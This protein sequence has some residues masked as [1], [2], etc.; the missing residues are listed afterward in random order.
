MTLESLG[1]RLPLS[2]RAP[3]NAPPVDS[4]AVDNSPE[5]GPPPPGAVESITP[6]LG[7]YERYADGVAPEVAAATETV[8][9]ALAIPVNIDE[10]ELFAQGE[11]LGEALPELPLAD[12]A[13]TVLDPAEITEMQALLEGLSEQLQSDVQVLALR[14]GLPLEGFRSEGRLP[15]AQ[16]Q[17]LEA[18]PQNLADLEHALRSAIT[19]LSASSDIEH[20]AELLSQLQTGLQEVSA[21]QSLLEHSAA[22]NSARLE[23]LA[24]PGNLRAYGSRMDAL[25][26]QQQEFVSAMANTGLE[27]DWMDQASAEILALTRSDAEALRGIVEAPEAGLVDLALGAGKNYFNVRGRQGRLNRLAYYS[28]FIADRRA[29]GRDRSNESANPQGYLAGLQ[30]EVHDSEERRQQ[31]ARLSQDIVSR[32]NRPMSDGEIRARVN[33]IFPVRHDGTRIVSQRVY[34]F[35]LSSFLAEGAS[36]RSN[37]HL[38]Q[39]RAHLGA[40]GENLGDARAHLSDDEIRQARQEILETRRSLQSADDH[41]S[42]GTVASRRA[43]QGENIQAL[44]GVPDAGERV[45]TTRASVSGRATED[46]FAAVQD[47]IA[48]LEDESNEVEA[49]VDRREAELQPEENVAAGG[50]A[51]LSMPLFSGER[52]PGVAPPADYLERLE[53]YSDNFQTLLEDRLDAPDVRG[54]SPSEEM[55]TL[56]QYRQAMR[57]L[58]RFQSGVME[59]GERE[60]FEGRRAAVEA[61]F[62]ELSNAPAVQNM[63]R[64]IQQEALSNTGLDGENGNYGPEDHADYILSFE[65]EVEMSALSLSER[66]ARVSQEISRLAVV[67]AGMA[68]NVVERLQQAQNQRQP[69]EILFEGQTPA[70]QEANVARALDAFAQEVRQSFMSMRSDEAREAAFNQLLQ[71]IGGGSDASL[72]WQKWLSD[73]GDESVLRQAQTI[74]GPEL[75]NADFS[76]LIRRGGGDLTAAIRHSGSDSARLLL[77]FINVRSSESGLRMVGAAAGVIGSLA[78]P[79]AALS[80]IPSGFSQ[81][82]ATADPFLS[83]SRNPAWTALRAGA[84]EVTGIYGDL[85]ALSRSLTSLTQGRYT[86]GGNRDLQLLTAGTAVV[87]AGLGV[88]ALAG[89][90]IPGANVLA[91]GTAATAA[92]V[93]YAQKHYGETQREEDVYELLGDLGITAEE[94]DSRSRLS[95]AL[96]TMGPLGESLTDQQVTDIV[97]SLV[98]RRP[99]GFL[100]SIALRSGGN[101]LGLPAGIL[102]HFRNIRARGAENDAEALELL[103]QVAAS[104]SGFSRAQQQAILSRLPVETF[105]HNFDS[106]SEAQELAGLMFSLNGDQSSPQLEQYLTSLSDREDFSAVESV[107]GSLRGRRIGEESALETL[108]LDTIMD[109][110]VNYIQD[111]RTEDALRLVMERINTPSGRDE[112]VP[113]TRGRQG[114]LRNIIQGDWLGRL[115]ATGARYRG[116]PIAHA[117]YNGLRERMPSLPE[118]P[119]QYLGYQET[120]PRVT[121]VRRRADQLIDRVSSWRSSGD[122]DA[123]AAERVSQE[124]HDF[125]NGTSSAERETLAERPRGKVEE[126]LELLTTEYQRGNRNHLASF[127]TVLAGTDRG[128]R[129][130]LIEAFEARHPEIAQQAIN[131]ATRALITAHE[132]H[133]REREEEQ[134][135]IDSGQGFPFNPMGA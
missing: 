131:P 89:L 49:A 7:R 84:A 100:A 96:D 68:H 111:N 17:Q 5:T 34:D 24:T 132:E 18:M 115:N 122:Y 56:F 6:A 39:S 114:E 75:S 113:L 43:A 3:D 44:E 82:L 133:L 36:V 61:R 79:T 78:D 37:Y 74:L 35:F 73:L 60:A 98:N 93:S 14:A 104:E 50:I 95:D 21:T 41:A 66:E 64:S 91:V 110:A 128:N 57:L 92:L 27:A 101:P 8:M 11:L 12:L 127:L 52:T 33:D 81:G 22:L 15:Q 70:E 59:Q 119:H 71:N 30:N 47:E 67:D 16:A 99:E 108:S 65:F 120:R 121:D 103:A 134:R 117:I 87:G 125:Y 51:G 10:A 106:A 77:G 4:A 25:A 20:H 112:M 102:S 23:L 83:F 63:M 129:F 116:E 55:Q 31:C 105:A 135:R 130:E 2:Q 76:R 46:Q 94:A 62:V 32:R 107:I 45:S 80:R 69:A 123:A 124:I 97:N 13:T 29:D 26:Q 109:V 42:S 54:D 90:A 85:S 86:S 28:A 53:N 19:Q 9:G 40:A 48:A 72:T 126:F 88:A 1:P 58:G 118:N 38:D